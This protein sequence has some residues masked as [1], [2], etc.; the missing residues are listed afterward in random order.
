MKSIARKLSTLGATLLAAASATTASAQVITPGNPGGGVFTPAPD[1]VLAMD[2]DG[3]GQFDTVSVSISF[4]ATESTSGKVDISTPGTGVI[5]T[6]LS[7]H[8]ADFFGGAY[9]V[10][11]DLNGDGANEIAI[12]APLGEDGNNGSGVVYIYSALSSSPI[13]QID[14]VNGGVFGVGLKYRR[15]SQ[16]FGV[17]ARKELVVLTDPVH[18]INLYNSSADN[19]YT[20]ESFDLT[21]GLPVSS[22][23]VLDFHEDTN[24]GDLWTFSPGVRSDLNVDGQLNFTDLSIVLNLM[25][26]TAPHAGVILKGDIDRDGDVDGDDVLIVADD[27]QNQNFLLLAGQ[28]QTAGIPWKDIIKRAK[29]IGKS[30]GFFA[31]VR[32]A[33]C[34]AAID[35]LIYTC[36]FSTNTD[37]EYVGCV[38]LTLGDPG[39]VGIF[40]RASFLGY[41]L[42]GALSDYIGCSSVP[43]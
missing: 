21:T 22:G 37:E 5:D 42:L 35:A 6:I 41:D 34:I 17:P 8:A 43:V 2:Y 20:C 31:L 38:C 29:G 9:C 36:E 19:Y 25:G 18:D 7:P 13:A 32:A 11:P 16:G 4:S 12:S 26:T 3:N 33:A 28:A 23:S 24:W 40:C 10:L 27:V 14:R 39:G 30:V 15:V 1:P